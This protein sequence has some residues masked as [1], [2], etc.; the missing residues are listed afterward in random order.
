MTELLLTRGLP[1]SGKTTWA[2]SLVR[3]AE[4]EWSRVNRD[5]TRMSLYGVTHGLT[6]EQ[7]QTVTEH[8]HS[9]ARGLL[10]AGI[11]V[12]IDDTNLNKQ[13]VKG[14]QRLAVKEHVIFSHRDFEIDVEECILRA[15]ERTRL[16]GRKVPTEAIRRMHKRYL[17]KGFPSFPANTVSVPKPYVPNTRNP[18]AF[19]VDIDGTMTL[20]PHDRGP[21]EWHK[22]GRDKPRWAVIDLVEA[23]AGSGDYKIIF[24]S[25]RSEEAREATEQWLNTAFMYPYEA[26]FMRPAGDYRPDNVIK[27]E[28]FDREIRDQYNVIASIDDRDQVVRYW[29][30]IGLTCLQV[31][32]GDF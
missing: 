32:E 29:R 23:V 21:F 22:V 7:E 30:S 8:Q 11:S 3:G 18:A 4:G 17:S 9:T 14:W 28:I 20:G 24:L 2:E 16:G 19:I 15:A 10:R 6:T 25:G 26:L 13:T 12:V 5:E 31:D 27:A 1:G